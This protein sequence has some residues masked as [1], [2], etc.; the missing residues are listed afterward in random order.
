M[1]TESRALLQDYIIDVEA[2]KPKVS[3]YDVVLQNNSDFIIRRKTA[4]L[5]QDLVVL[6]SKDLYYLKN[7][8]TGAVESLSE[9][10]LRTFLRNL[11]DGM[12]PLDQVL[13]MPHLFKESADR[14]Y[15]V[16]T[17]AKFAEMCRHNVMGNVREPSW[18]YRYWDQNSK[19]LI[20]LNTLFPT[21]S[22][23]K[24][25]KYQNS[26]PL[27]YELERRYGAN[28]AIYFAEQLVRS[29]IQSFECGAKHNYLD[30]ATHDT[31]GFTRL[32]DKDFNL[33]LRRLIDYVLFDLYRQGYAKI[34][35]AF[36]TEY[37]DYLRMQKEFHGKIREKYPES[38]KTAHDVIALKVN[39]ARQA[40]V[41]KDFSDR[42]GEVEHLAYEGS[43][44]CIVVPSQPKELADEGINLSHCV[45]DYISRVASGDCHILFLRRKHAPDQS[46][47]TL[48]L[49]G[50]SICPGTG[51][52][53]P[54][55]H[56]RRAEVPLQLGTGE[57]HP[58]RCVM[59]H[60]TGVG[61]IPLHA[62][63]Q[64][65]QEDFILCLSKNGICAA[66]AASTWS[67][68]MWKCGT[69]RARSRRPCRS[70]WDCPRKSMC[71]G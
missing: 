10:N 40:A 8:K 28:E 39:L 54:L 12:I 61:H 64:S 57:Q 2:A 13:W 69:V 41:C 26:I 27:I 45:G 9:S 37:Y 49:S 24:N 66:T 60:R 25:G 29:G 52:E 36:W 3:G 47:V 55:N 15:R 32:L 7:V 56:K 58:N 18:Y 23:G 14:I 4:K 42:V 11:Q 38:L 43:R 65:V 30:S 46:L 63:H 19:L 48:Q 68:T 71:A 67:T 21:I 5:E 33:N 34:N 16:V 31:D 22:D 62:C 59:Q 51:S 44:Y 50:Q 1:T 17:D 35:S 6:V 53:P 20:R 70:F